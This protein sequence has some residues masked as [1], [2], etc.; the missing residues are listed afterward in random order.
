[1]KRMRRS[2]QRE[3]ILAYLQSTDSHPTAQKI[4]EDLLP[5]FPSL[6]LGTI[7]RNLGILEEQGKVHKLHY[8]STFDRFDAETERH[9]HFVCRRCGRIYD[10]PFDKD[11]TLKK[12]T[13]ALSPHRVEDVTLDFHGV[14]AACIED[15]RRAKEGS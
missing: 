7:Y 15:E 6:S 11:S 2:K 1:M 3:E 14:C 13:E 10:I 5:E 9:S 12:R 8:G 4:Y